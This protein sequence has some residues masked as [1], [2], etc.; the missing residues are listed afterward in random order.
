MNRPHQL[1]LRGRVFLQHDPAETVVTWPVVKE[2]VDQVFS[3]VVIM[4][5]RR[6]EAAAIEVERIRPV[7]I[8]AAARDQIVVGVAP[9]GPGD[10]ALGGTAVAF[11]V[12]VEEPEQPVA[13]AEAG[14]PDAARIRVAEH[15]Q[16]CLSPQRPREQSPVN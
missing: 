11:H 8:D 9:A 6:I 14:R 13:V 16:L 5:E 12:R 3:A 2:H 10:A 1:A 4:E 15:V 7:A